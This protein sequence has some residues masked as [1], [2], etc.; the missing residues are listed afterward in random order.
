MW[1]YGHWFWRITSVWQTDMP[2][3]TANV[4]YRDLCW[5]P[6]Q[7]HTVSYVF[8]FLLKTSIDTSIFYLVFRR[9]YSTRLLS[10][11]VVCQLRRF[12]NSRQGVRFQLPVFLG[13]GLCS[14][15]NAAVKHSLSYNITNVKNRRTV[16][17]KS[18][19]SPGGST[20]Q[21]AAARFAV[22]GTTTL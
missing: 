14:N 22:P 10:L 4:K 19:K 9:H 20:L 5:F 3:V 1:S 6:A 8:C 11:F 18:L 2:P 17:L 21:W 7:V 13:F 15:Y 16:A 12:V